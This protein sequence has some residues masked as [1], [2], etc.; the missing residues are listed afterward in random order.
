M[1]RAL[2]LRQGPA[3][4]PCACS[5]Q[6]NFRASARARSPR[7]PGKAPGSPSPAGSRG[8]RAV[9]SGSGPGRVRPAPSGTPRPHWPAP[10]PPP[11][12]PAYLAGRPGPGRRRAGRGRAMSHGAGLVRTTCSSGGGPGAGA[13]QPGARP[14]EGPLD[15]IYPRTYS[16][17]L[18]VAQMVR[19][20]RGAGPGSRGEARQEGE[21]GGGPPGGWGR[22]GPAGASRRG[23][24]GG[25]RR[26]SQ[27]RGGLPSESWVRC[28]GPGTQPR[29][30]P[31]SRGRRSPGSQVFFQPPLCGARPAFLQKPQAEVAFPLPSSSLGRAASNP[32]RG[33]KSRPGGAL[34]RRNPSF[35]PSRPPLSSQRREQGC[36]ALGAVS[37]RRGSPKAQFSGGKRNGD[38]RGQPSWTP[39]LSSSREGPGLGAGG[40]GAGWRRIDGE[41]PS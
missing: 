20:A 38:P 12:R 27:V 32:S 14:S 4:R 3:H 13:G 8:G 6:A 11:A 23:R 18:K 28:R 2:P 24:A 25:P 10:A 16:A 7:P 5:R 29:R 41:G 19:E 36:P 35:S 39:A 31:C 30:R 15:P 9:V 26:H 33:W 22:A 21:P 40:W 17:L 37:Q 34:R 1:A